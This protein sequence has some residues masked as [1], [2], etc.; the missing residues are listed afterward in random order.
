MSLSFQDEVVHLAGQVSVEDA[1]LLL[2][3]LLSNPGAQVDLQHLQHLHSANLQVLM[4][5]RP[6]V[7]QWPSDTDTHAWLAAALNS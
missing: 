7:V 6:P 1:E 4:V 2:E 3:W 5:I